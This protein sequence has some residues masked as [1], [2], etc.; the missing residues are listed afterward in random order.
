MVAGLAQWV[1]E[2]VL[3]LA[4]LQPAQQ[5]Q[6]GAEGEGLRLVERP[7]LDQVHRLVLL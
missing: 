2:P 6:V 1:P 5:F 4:G 7:G 3:A